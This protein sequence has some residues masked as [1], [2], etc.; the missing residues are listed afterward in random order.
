ML[1]WLAGLIASALVILSTPFSADLTAFLPDRPSPEQQILVDQLKSGMVSRMLLIGI[2]GGEPAERARL[3]KTLAASLRADPRFVLVANGEA[4]ALAK[5]RQLLFEQRY[6]LSPAVTPERF[7]VAGLRQAVQATLDQLAS[8]AGMLIERLVP[9]DP[10]GELITLVTGALGGRG[11]HS[12]MGVWTSTDGQRALLLV[13]TRATGVDLDGQAAS[14][15]AVQAAFAAARAELPEAA[16]SRLLVS[17]PSVFAVEARGT[18]H[19]QSVALALAGLTLIVALLLFMFRSPVGLVLSLVPVLSGAAAAAAVVGLVFGELQGV[20]LG[21]GT[22]LIGEAVD[23]SIYLLVQSSGGAGPGQGERHRAWLQRFWPTIRLGVLTSLIGFGALLFSSFPGLAQI[24]VFSITGLTVAALVT[25]FVL[26]ALLPA[27]LPLRDLA[28]LGH[29]VEAWLPALRRL[30]L[31]L[32]LPVLAAV[33]ALAL[34][35]RGLW[36]QEL[37]ALSPVPEAARMLDGEL[38][39]DLGAPDTRYLVLVEGATPEAALQAAERAAGKLQPLVDRGVLA[40]FD[41][42][43]RYLPSAQTQAARQA[44]LPPPAELRARLAAALEGMPLRP[45]KLEPFIADVQA[46]Q[47]AKPVT[48]ADLAG[49]SFAVAVEALLLRQDDRWAGLLPLRSPSQGPEALQID[50]AAVRAALADSDARLIDFKAETDQLYQDY[51][52]QAIWL[53]LAGVAAILLLLSLALRSVLR[54]VR[55]VAPLAAVVLVVTAGLTLAGVTLN[56]LHLVGMLL[57]VAVGSNYALFFERGTARAGP[58]LLASLLLANATTVLSFGMLAFSSI[59]VL[60][61]IGASVAPGALLAL[62]FA[63]I[64]APGSDQAAASPAPAPDPVR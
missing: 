46:A 38:R 17:G 22:T 8:P 14:I 20:T 51:L 34:V 10:T 15:A 21:F 13:Y 31:W 40:G 26:P 33:L 39:A 5:D 27:R 49:S 45:A 7:T 58:R 41:T 54:A 36:S 56:L 53:S 4:A 55:V 1:A 50:V 48:L 2:E 47:A 60:N 19:R 12:T 25:R 9:R 35:Q 11:P 29:R 61:A 42:P 57:I 62:L 18:I 28:G 63:A 64:L 44:A 6:L 23:Y 43:S 37:A 16:A 32:I 30:R 59:P 3:S 52:G 24:G